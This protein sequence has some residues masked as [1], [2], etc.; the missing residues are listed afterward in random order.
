M[1]Q[2]K[3]SFFKLIVRDVEKMRGFY[4]AAFG[5]AVHD[6]FE[7]PDF[8]EVLMRQTGSDFMLVLLRY[9][10][11]RDVSAAAAHGPSGFVTPDMRSTHAQLQAAGAAA[12]TPVMEV[13][14]MKVAFFDDP[15]GHE[16]EVVQF[17]S[18]I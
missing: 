3:L 2:A 6:S 14:D 16:I 8:E 7:T 1:A 12:K 10:D 13:D 11:G 15:E 17:G 4:E 5:F 18:G 9:K